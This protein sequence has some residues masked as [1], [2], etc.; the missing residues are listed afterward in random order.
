MKVKANKQIITFPF[1][2]FSIW[3]DRKIVNLETCLLSFELEHHMLP[4]PSCPSPAEFHRNKH[5]V[6][7]C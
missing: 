7:K 6:K 3:G 5:G 2:K 4:I 1:A